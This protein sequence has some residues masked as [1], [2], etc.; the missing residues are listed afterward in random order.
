M[1]IR[2]QK[3]DFYLIKLRGIVDGRPF[4]RTVSICK[5]LIRSV[6]ESDVP[7]IKGWMIAEG[8]NPGEHDVE[9]YAQSFRENGFFVLVDRK[10]PD[11]P[12]GCIL[13]PQY[14]KGS[15]FIGLYIIDPAYRKK[16]YG[17]KMWNYA[18]DQLSARDIMLYAVEAEVGRYENAGFNKV[19][20]HTKRFQSGKNLKRLSENSTLIPTPIDDI[21]GKDVRPLTTVRPQDGDDEKKRDEWDKLCNNITNWLTK[22]Y[23]NHVNADFIKS[24]LSHDGITAVIKIDSESVNEDVVSEDAIRGLAILRP[25]H[26]GNYRLSMFASNKESAVDLVIEAMREINFG[27]RQC[28]KN[29]AETNYEPKDALSIF[30]DS[31]NPDNSLVKKFVGHMEFTCQAGATFTIMC[32]SGIKPVEEEKLASIEQSASIARHSLFFHNASTPVSTVPE[33]STAEDSADN[34]TN[35]AT[36]SLEVG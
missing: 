1:S 24:L 8:W 20:G 26:D 4:I 27:A 12:L 29:P 16:G 2:S 36:L 22:S 13:A 14:G 11:T 28:D 21:P 34:P 33:S 30:M 6:E 18:M 31:M 17:R 35:I 19:I 10:N 5:T 9:V 7:T 3:N 25:C 15:A 23:T 32:K